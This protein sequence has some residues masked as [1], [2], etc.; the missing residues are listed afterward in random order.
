MFKYLYILGFILGS[1][2]FVSNAQCKGFTKRRCIPELG[3]YVFNG[4]LNTAIL[5]RGED[6]ELMLS[7]YSGQ[8]YRMYVCNEEQLGNVEYEIMDIDRNVIYKS[9]DNENKLFDFKV[10]S[11][12]QLILH[13][14]V[15]GEKTKHALDFRGCVSILV[16]F[17]EE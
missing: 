17:I 7:F 2:P 15:L 10:P 12:Q 14:T 11:T 3:E 13:V 4:Q 6:A 9:K 8:K 5:T 16:G 1:I